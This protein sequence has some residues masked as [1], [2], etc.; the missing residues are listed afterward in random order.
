MFRFYKSSVGKI[1]NLLFT[2]NHDYVDLDMLCNDIN[3]SH[4]NMNM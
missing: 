2:E 1:V 3:N 4:V